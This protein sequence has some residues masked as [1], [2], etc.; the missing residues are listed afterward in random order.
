MAIDAS[1]AR[2]RELHFRSAIER[3]AETKLIAAKQSARDIVQMRQRG[4]ILK[5]KGAHDL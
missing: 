1:R 3:D 2:C 5:R 4:S